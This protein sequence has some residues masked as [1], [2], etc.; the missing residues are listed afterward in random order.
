VLR[1]PGMTSA[2][3]G[4][5]TVQQVEDNVAALSKLDFSQD[6]LQAI[7]RIAG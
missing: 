6:E 7:D 1:H 2:L 4:A 3:I 5:S